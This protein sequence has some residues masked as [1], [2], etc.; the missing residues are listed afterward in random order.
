[1]KYTSEIIKTEYFASHNAKA[2][3]ALEYG[4]FYYFFM[5]YISSTVKYQFSEQRNQWSIISKIF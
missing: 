4:G 5:G 1:M 3:S 2:R